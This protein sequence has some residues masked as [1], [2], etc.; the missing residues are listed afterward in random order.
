LDK[1]DRIIQEHEKIGRNMLIKFYN[2]HISEIESARFMGASADM[3]DPKQ[4][5]VMFY[6]MGASKAISNDRSTSN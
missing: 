6:F 3:N 4:V 5:A 1:L 2:E